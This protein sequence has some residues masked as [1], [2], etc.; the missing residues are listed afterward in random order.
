MFSFLGCIFAGMTGIRLVFQVYLASYRKEIC[1]RSE[2]K[3]FVLDF[4]GNG[5]PFMEAEARDLRLE[6]VQQLLGLY[7]Q[8]VTKYRKLSE[9]LRQLSIDENQLLNNHQRQDMKEKIEQ[10]LEQGKNGTNYIL[11]L[12]LF[13]LVDYVWCLVSVVFCSWQ[14]WRHKVNGIQLGTLPIYECCRMVTELCM[15][16]RKL[17]I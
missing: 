12:P 15:S 11:L 13:Y 6:D 14:Q 3:F 8:V 1:L 7:K 17:L 5:Y 2:V 10:Q 16:V 9:A 4:A